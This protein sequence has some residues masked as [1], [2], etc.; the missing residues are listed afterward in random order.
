MADQRYPFVAMSANFDTS[1]DNIEQKFVKIHTF[2]PDRGDSVE[3]QDARK[4]ITLP[5]V[6]ITEDG[7]QTQVPMTISMTELTEINKQVQA[8]A[9]ARGWKL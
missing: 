6:I 3:M 1:N 9:E 7:K 8:I 4:W 5:T 2:G